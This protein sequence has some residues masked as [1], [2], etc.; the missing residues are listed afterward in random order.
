MWSRVIFIKH[1]G[2]KNKT[3]YI[4]IYIYIYTH[5]EGSCDTVDWSNDAENSA[6][7][8]GL[9]YILKYKKKKKKNCYNIWQCLFWSNKCCLIE[10]KRLLKNI[11][12]S[13]RPQTFIWTLPVSIYVLEITELLQCVCGTHPSTI[14]RHDPSRQWSFPP[15]HQTRKL[16]SAPSPMARKKGFLS[17][18]F[19]LHHCCK[20]NDRTPGVSV[21]YALN[22]MTGKERACSRFNL[23]ENN[24]RTSWK[25]IGLV[26]AKASDGDSGGRPRA[27]LY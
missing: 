18:Q 21:Q 19:H 24:L 12:K 15:S 9:N 27:G 22:N 26:W 5:S 25:R 16:F 10:H 17:M 14:N 13:Y 2:Q 3:L 8:T 23:R 6:L 11:Y 7:N 1:S 20:Y 4:Y